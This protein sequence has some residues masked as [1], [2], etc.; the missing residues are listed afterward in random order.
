VTSLKHLVKTLTLTGRT[1]GVTWFGVVFTAMFLTYGYGIWRH[2]SASTR[3][4][5]ILVF[6][7]LM[8]VDRVARWRR[9]RRER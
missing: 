1:I 8:V 5:E 2:W 6:F 7:A 3:G 4:I 9:R